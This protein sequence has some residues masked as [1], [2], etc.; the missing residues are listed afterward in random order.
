MTASNS[1]PPTSSVRVKT[2]A[3]NTREYDEAAMHK[4]F[5]D[6][7]AA[8]QARPEKD[9]GFNSV[10]VTPRSLS[11]LTGNLR[12]FV[13]TALGRHG[14]PHFKSKITKFPHRLFMDYKPA[15]ALDIMLCACLNFKALHGL[16]RLEFS[17]VDKRDFYFDLLLRIDRA[18][19]QAALLPTVKVFFSPALPISEHPA[20]S[21]TVHKR[22]ITVTSPAA[23]THVVYPDPPET[24]AAETEGTDYCRPLQIV[25]NN[26]FVHWWYYP[27]SYDSWIPRGD[28]DGDP[29]AAEEVQHPWHVQMRWLQDTEMF[30]E[31][32]NEIDYEVPEEMRMDIP[33]VPILEAAPAQISP[34]SAAEEKP[35]KTEQPGKVPR[36]RRRMSSSISNK[37]NDHDRDSRTHMSSR[38]DKLNV[39]NLTDDS[40]EET[41]RKPRRHSETRPGRGKES[42]QRSRRDATD[43]H[44][45][46]KKA[47]I[48]DDGRTR[49]VSP[50][51]SVKVRLT[52]KA[53]HERKDRVKDRTKET[54][55]GDSAR[56][57]IKESSAES[58]GL[59]VR[60]KLGK[61]GDGKQRTIDEQQDVKLSGGDAPKGSDN[62]DVSSALSKIPVTQSFDEN[63]T[64]NDTGK[65]GDVVK[66]SSDVGGAQKV[67]NKQLD[68][69]NPPA[70]GVGGQEQKRPFSR[71]RGK[72]K[73]RRQNRMQG[74][75]L[76]E[77]AVPI[78]E[79]EVPRIRNI[80]NEGTNVTAVNVPSGSDADEEAVD[81]NRKVVVNEKIEKEKKVAATS[82]ENAMEVDGG[83]DHGRIMAVSEKMLS[84]DGANAPVSGTDIMKGLPPVKVRV[85]AHARW[86]RMDAI[87]D[88][89]K[90]SLSEFFNSRG[91][92]KTPMVYKKY[93]DFMIDVWR[94]APDKY[95]TATAARRHLTG[96]VCAI[97]RVHAFLEYWG[98]INY[99]TDPETKPYLSSSLRSRHSRPTPMH[100]DAHFPGPANGVP[101]ILFFDEP[102]PPAREN[103]PVSL[104]KAVK[105]AK[106]KSTRERNPILSRRELYA[107]AA[108]TKYECDACGRD[109]SR[110][111]YHCVGNA[112]MEL[113][114][115]CFADGMYPETL[116]ARDFE[117]LTT[118]LSSEA[119]DGTVWSESE[120]L[121][122]LEALE[123]YNDD[124]NQVAEHVGTKNNEQ[125]VLQFLRMPFEDSFLE[126]QIG[127][128]APGAD[129]DVDVDILQEEIATGKHKF[130]GQLLPFHDTSNPV[131]AQVAF[132]ASSV[133]P[134]VAAAAAQAA[135]NKIMNQSGVDIETHEEKRAQATALLKAS[136]QDAGRTSVENGGVA[137]ARTENGLS[138]L[139]QMASKELDTA[140]VE[141]AAAVGLAAA[142]TKAQQLCEKENREIERRFAAVV[143]TKLRCVDLKLKEFERLEVHLRRERERLEKQRQL[144]F[145]ERVEASMGRIKSETQ[146]EMSGGI[147]HLGG[148]AGPPKVGVSR[149]GQTSQVLGGQ[150]ATGGLITAGEGIGLR[151]MGTMRMGGSGSTGM[152]PMGLSMLGGVVG[153]P[154]GFAGNGVGAMQSG[155][156][157][158][159]SNERVRMG[160]M[161]FGAGGQGGLMT[162]Q[163]QDGIG[164]RGDEIGVSGQGVMEMGEGS[165][166]ALEHGG[167]GGIMSGGVGLQRGLGAENRRHGQAT[168]VHGN[169]QVGI[170]EDK[171]DT[172]ISSRQMG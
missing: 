146:N 67:V 96:D 21:G 134:E 133:D 1:Q 64:P 62:D 66:R 117:Q 118:V 137:E 51:S 158:L 156:V 84:G 142:A 38:K 151:G 93:R 112:D 113:C 148:V 153:G 81:G 109:C 50:N 42:S 68:G 29:E 83:K 166:G 115:S 150:G 128:W 39:V 41:I 26:A 65:D 100:L 127:N 155:Q 48:S 4:R 36:K 45:V 11:L 172:D 52:L 111:R 114:P 14:N 76:V 125:C 88:I 18:L 32:M 121:L 85:P 141:A 25:D 160:T 34:P 46:R 77:D 169:E 162:G 19:R 17:N 139:S 119:Y 170:R 159:K 163:G 116:S 15:G 107:T 90:R 97:L 79:G 94:Q 154:G 165:A 147:T 20:L 5:T 6:I 143:E 135:L 149:S 35:P 49:K 92:S 28:V 152:R 157:D 130:E 87:H 86:F 102:R 44:Q 63:S 129:N 3:V 7:C 60:V 136:E 40:E 80:S 161:G 24:T 164:T 105:A 124:W 171:I 9:L 37:V 126:D 168:S 16:R 91:E 74:M 73:E 123:K 110:M 98:L 30:N 138:N 61:S 132:L 108:A 99:G 144:V 131:M 2:A 103:A 82:G 33:P 101:R 55:T 27:D 167:G 59:K 122:L 145:A 120:V 47:R 106:E 23:A 43:S 13:E 95:L 54:K 22:G 70:D 104:Q 89:E 69:E 8:I 31:W 140:A 57:D 75:T 72:K 58:K 71:R 12:Q 53:P 10:D 56:P 78:P